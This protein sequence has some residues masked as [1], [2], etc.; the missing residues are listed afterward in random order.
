MK[1]V[2]LSRSMVGMGVSSGV[3]SG[4]LEGIGVLVKV[5]VGE[6]VGVQV[7]GKTPLG[8][9][10]GVGVKTRAGN[11]VG[12]SGFNPLWGF[13]KMIANSSPTNIVPATK[14]PERRFRKHPAPCLLFGFICSI[15]S[16]RSIGVDINYLLKGPTK[17]K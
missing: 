15:S 5:A 1:V 7:N 9:G 10:V 8:V 6:T 4:V 3:G 12:G 14:V 11:V 17:V 13:I 2:P 16:G